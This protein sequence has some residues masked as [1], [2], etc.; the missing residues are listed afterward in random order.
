MS[1]KASI[2]VGQAGPAAELGTSRDG[3]AQPLRPLGLAAVSL[4]VAALAAATFVLSYSGIHALVRQAGVSS[5]YASDY[6]LLIDAM[7]VI[8][9]LAVLGLRGAGIPS[10]ILAWLTL[11]AVL[12]AAAGADVL[13]ATGHVLQHNVSAATAAAL[14]WALVLLA[15]LLLLALLRH[16]RLRRHASMARRRQ[17]APVSHQGRPDAGPQAAAPATTLPVRVPQQWNSASDS[18]SIVPGLSSRLVSSAAAGAAAGAA[19]SA[20]PHSLTVDA[21]VSGEPST[22]GT[23]PRSAAAVGVSEVGADAEPADQSGVQTVSA[24]GPGTPGGT[25]AGPGGPH[26]VPGDA[27]AAPDTYAAPHADAPDTDAYGTDAALA[28]ADT[29]LAGTDAARADTDAA[30]ADTDAASAGTDEA[31]ADTS[32][33]PADAAPDIDAADADAAPAGSDAGP[34]ADGDASGTDGSGTDA[35]LADIDA[36]GGDA[37]P[38]PGTDAALADADAAPGEARGQNGSTDGASTSSGESAAANGDP[39]ASDPLAADLEAGELATEGQSSDAAADDMPVF[40]R[41]WSTPTPPDN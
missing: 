27:D 3:A 32:S 36:P 6:P 35:A 31:L 41:M 38:A 10:R 11:L 20:D 24:L 7:L 14:P 40:H 21:G 29:A 25:G 12:A 33:A 4:G 39:P 19:A 26:P 5:R 37:D 15:F 34:D 30:L 17:V 13:H 16:A 18:A 22:Y 28:A 23:D 8:A 1:E 2:Q 9:L